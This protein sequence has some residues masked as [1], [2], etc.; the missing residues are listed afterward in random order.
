MIMPSLIPIYLISN[1]PVNRAPQKSKSSISGNLADAYTSDV[2]FRA[3]SEMGEA[4]NAICAG[5]RKTRSG[6]GGR[7]RGEGRHRRAGRRRVHRPQGA[8][9]QADRPVL[10]V[11][12]AQP[13][14]RDG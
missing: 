9:R 12:V 7:L 3:V 10:D 4:P 11:A 6:S 5:S 13:R 14:V 2:L 1:S 8:P